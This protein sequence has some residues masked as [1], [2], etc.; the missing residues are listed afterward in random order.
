MAK[1]KQ[2]IGI[3]D[4]VRIV[5]PEFYIRTK[6]EKEFF[7]FYQEVGEKQ[8]DVVD[9]M[10]DVYHK[11]YFTFQDNYRAEFLLRDHV[12]KGIAACNMEKAKANGNKRIIETSNMYW[13]TNLKFLVYDTFTVATGEYQKSSDGWNDKDQEFSTQLAAL[14]N[15]TYHRILKVVK[16]EQIPEDETSEKL[17]I[18]DCNVRFLEKK[19]VDTPKPI[20]MGCDMANEADRNVVTQQPSVAFLDEL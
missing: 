3:G 18:E 16:F 4:I 6:Y 7:D 19:T 11:E 13:H 5:K 17:M 2:L 14:K 1:R 20:L 9:R 12:V 10:I 15:R 8:S